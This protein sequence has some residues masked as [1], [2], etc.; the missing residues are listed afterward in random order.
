MAQR[1]DF[2]R[3]ILQQ[4]LKQ[5]ERDMAVRAAVKCFAD[6]LNKE[7]EQDALAF[8]QAMKDKPSVQ[9]L[10]DKLKEVGYREAVEVFEQWQ[11]ERS[12]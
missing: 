10:C 8:A 12:D 4:N 9:L 11:S 2:Q 3:H 7:R 6:A 5:A 1:L